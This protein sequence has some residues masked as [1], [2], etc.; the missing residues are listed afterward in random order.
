MDGK[1]EKEEV[2]CGV[3]FGDVDSGRSGWGVCGVWVDEEE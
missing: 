2:V 3:H 1:V